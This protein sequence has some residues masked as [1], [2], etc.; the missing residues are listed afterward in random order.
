MLAQ[1]LCITSVTVH[2][3]CIVLD[4]IFV[5]KPEYLGRQ[6]QTLI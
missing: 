3:T 5:L 4:F 1:V 6:N 2:N